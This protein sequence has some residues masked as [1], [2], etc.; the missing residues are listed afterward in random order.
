MDG[1]HSWSST[2]RRSRN[3]CQRSGARAGREPH[4]PANLLP[5]A[6]K[7]ER[8]IVALRYYRDLSEARI[9]AEIGLSQVQVSRVLKSSLEKMRKALEPR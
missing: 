5:S 4:L 9:G 3:A 2:T 8:R 7:R 1:H 6:H